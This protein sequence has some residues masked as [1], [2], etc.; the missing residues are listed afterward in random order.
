MLQLG[1]WLFI[2]TKK[3]EVPVRRKSLIRVGWF[4]GEVILVTSPL[5]LVRGVRK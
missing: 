1:R 2:W 3:F 4:V 5:T